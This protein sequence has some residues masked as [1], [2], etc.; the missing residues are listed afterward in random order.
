MT[1]RDPGQSP[2]PGA[3]L[4][5]GLGFASLAIAAAEAAA[6]RVVA[7]ALGLPPKARTAFTLRML[8]LRELAAGASILLQPRR[9]L[10]LWARVAGDVADL[11]L[12]AWAATDKKANRGRAALAFAGLTAVTAFDVYAAIRTTRLQE[13]AQAPVM[14]SVTIHQPPAIVYS[15]FRDFQRLP[16]FMDWL[17]AVDERSDG[18]SHWVAKLPT[19][20]KVEWDAE[21]TEER[22]NE[23]IAWR[24]RDDA[25]VAHAGR[26]TFAKAPGRD[27]TEVRVEMVAGLPGWSR[28]SA[29]L[30]K[31]LA[32]P[33][34]KGDLRRFKQL[35]ET[36][37]VLK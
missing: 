20:Q 31:A 26:V 33:Q 32:K 30:A 27:S 4:T 13:A 3:A 35:M 19:G 6:P 23:V 22:T 29:L 36:G 1:S 37:E 2:A 34:I 10:P 15:Y 24:T 17:E 7:Q 21:I 8:G 9:P 28:K 11:G 16:Q 5:R 14:F 25:P 12:L 18:T